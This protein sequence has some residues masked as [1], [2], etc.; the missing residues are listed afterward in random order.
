MSVRK[1]HNS[2]RNHER[3]VL[4]YYQRTPSP[5]PSPPLS[6][7]S[8]IAKHPDLLLT[9]RNRTRKSTIGHRLHHILLRRRRPSRCK[10]YARTSRRSPPYGRAGLS[11]APVWVSRYATHTPA[12]LL[13]FLPSVRKSEDPP[14]IPHQQACPL[15]P[16]CPA[17]AA[18]AVLLPRASFPRRAAA[19]CLLSLPSRPLLRRAEM[20]RPCPV[21]LVGCP[22]RPLEVC[23]LISKGFRRRRWEVRA[24][25]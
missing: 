18:P 24:R 22:S 21:R 20:H 12:L 14:N 19:V 16:S 15:H 10:P 3:N 5:A 25:G 7:H 1:A 13:T 11:S 17:P 9:R 6:P 23:R 4:D 2:G 8:Y